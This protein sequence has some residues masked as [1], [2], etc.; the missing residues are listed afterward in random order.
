MLHCDS[1]VSEQCLRGRVHGSECYMIKER[2]GDL[3][4]ALTPLIAVLRMLRLL[5]RYRSRLG[6]LQEPLIWDLFAKQRVT[7]KQSVTLGGE[8]QHVARTLLVYLPS[9][10]GVIREGSSH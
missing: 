2:V 9:T 4:G 1:Q 3:A 8:L 10:V 7:A 5:S 6:L